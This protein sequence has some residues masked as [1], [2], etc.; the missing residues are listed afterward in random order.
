MSYGNGSSSS[1]STSNLYRS[2]S[3]ASLSGDRMVLGD[4]FRSSYALR[5]H[6]AAVLK[7]LGLN[8]KSMSRI[9]KHPRPKR[10]LEMFSAVIKGLR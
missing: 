7:E 1:G 5:T 10:T 3:M 6:R 2:Q 4:S 8:A 9:P